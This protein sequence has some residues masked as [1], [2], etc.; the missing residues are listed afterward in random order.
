M[1]WDD[2]GVAQTMQRDPLAPL[3]VGLECEIESV[4]DH[5]NAGGVWNVTT[6][7][8]LRNNGFEYI[9]PP[10]TVEV[11]RA[12][13]RNLHSTIKIGKDA[14]TQR[15]SIHVHANLANLTSEVGRNIVLMYA[16]FEEAFFLMCTGDRRDNIHCT[17]LTETYLPSMYGTSF[18]N[19]VSK[20]HKYT[21]LNI[22]PIAKQG[23]I[24]FRHMHGHNDSVLLDEWLG[25]IANLIEVGKATK[26]DAN[27]FN[28]IKLEQVYQQ[29][30]GNSRLKDHYVLVRGMMANQ[31]L[32][33][34]LAVI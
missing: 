10:I 4:S 13:F 28:E 34:K 27:L 1:I 25:I 3:F 24:E 20:W 7:G 26:V 29:I 17:P 23:T 8:S 12:N 16:L 18:H 6:D 2:Y 5:G 11:A 14:F 32:D 22:K 30:F 31:I 33:V 9:S 19:M 15:T 21:A